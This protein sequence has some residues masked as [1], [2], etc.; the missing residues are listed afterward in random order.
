ME[1][2]YINRATQQIEI[3][4][5]PAKGLLKFLYHNPFGKTTVLPI[6]K[7]KIISDFYG[8]R[9]DSSSSINKIAKFVDT[10]HINMSESQKSI[11]EFSSFNDFIS[12][13]LKPESRK[14]QDGFVSPGDG[15]IIA[16]ENISDLNKFYVKGRPF[17]VSEFLK[18][19]NLA[20]KYKDCSLLIL[21][22]APN[23]YH[24]YH[25]PCQGVPSVSTKIKGHYLSVSPI[26]LV[27]NF[28]KVFCENKREYTVLSTPSKGDIIISPVG[29]TMFGSIISTYTA[30][31]EITK[32]DEMGYF[33]FGG[34][35]IVI[36]VEKGKIKIDRDILENTKNKLE[37]F[38]QMGEKIAQ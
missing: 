2:K 16:F 25:F 21:R 23:D 36:L 10:L 24:R 5:P 33:C 34:S 30:G 14:I 17:S 19:N 9:M 3:E 8:K 31:Q 13:K 1:I 7:Q 18:D 27:N 29:A 35:T 15:K 20:Q 22:L 4:T 37:T 26:A 32:G 12:R 11:T 28:S 6:V 38:V